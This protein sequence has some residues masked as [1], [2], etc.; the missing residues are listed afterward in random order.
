MSARQ[1]SASSL[2]WC[3]TYEDILLFQISSAWQGTYQHTVESSAR[4]KPALLSAAA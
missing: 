1:Y 3:K 2:F 4:L